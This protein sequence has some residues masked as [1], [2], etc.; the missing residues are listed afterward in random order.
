MATAAA[1]AKQLESFY[2]KWNAAGPQSYRKDRTELRDPQSV[3]NERI[4]ARLLPKECNYQRYLLVRTQEMQHPDDTMFAMQFLGCVSTMDEAN[5]FT[6]EMY[7]AGFDRFPIRVVELNHWRVFPPPLTAEEG[8]VV[9][10]QEILRQ[11]M[12]RDMDELNR[13]EEEMTAR[14]EAA[15][16]Q[17]AARRKAAEAAHAKGESFDPD[18]FDKKYNGDSD[19]KEEAKVEVLDDDDEKTNQIELPRGDDGKV[20]KP[21]ASTVDL[22][23]LSPEER[24]DEE[25]RFIKMASEKGK[26]P[27]KVTV[28]DKK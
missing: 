13:Q 23:K 24:K 15:K 4:P 14:V 28:T 9:Y 8:D 3:A 2:S 10:H 25:E 27:I 11:I 6:E 21:L 1:R 7:H 26:I 22:S 20:K 5:A 12:Q 17:S 18:E 19:E 16:R